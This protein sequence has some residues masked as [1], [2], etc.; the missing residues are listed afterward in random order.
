MA[1]RSGF[2]PPS[3]QIGLDYPAHNTGIRGKKR[4]AP[5]SNDL[6][7]R[8]QQRTEANLTLTVAQGLLV[9]QLVPTQR[10]PLEQ[11]S[12]LID[13]D[14]NIPSKLQIVRNVMQL[15]EAQYSIFIRAKEN[16]DSIYEKNIKL[17]LND[18]SYFSRA[19]QAQGLAFFTLQMA[20][21]ALISLVRR[22]NE[23]PF[24]SNFLKCNP[25]LFQ[26]HLQDNSTHSSSNLTS[27][28]DSSIS[29]DEV[30]LPFPR[31]NLEPSPKTVFQ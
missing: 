16:Y 28:L 22:I 31:K 14:C 2:D 12:P 29:L 1:I 5:K 17:I 19:S 13:L 11:S 26:A 8:K 9:Q 7:K 3:V 6:P 23:V 27:K 25:T 30:S 10:T 24:I 15:L 20:D 4:S 21:D 18:I